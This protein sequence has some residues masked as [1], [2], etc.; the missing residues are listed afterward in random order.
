MIEKYIKLNSAE[1]VKKLVKLINSFDFNVLLSEGNY[2]VNAKSILRVLSLDFGKPI[3]LV[4]ECDPNSDFEKEL[5]VLL[6]S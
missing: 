4:A 6:E 2:T 3:K 5:D 1:Q